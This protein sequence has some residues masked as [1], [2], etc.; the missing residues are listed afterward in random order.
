MRRRKGHVRFRRAARQFGFV[1][2]ING[3]ARDKLH[4]H[5]GLFGKFFGDGLI[6]QIFKTAAPRA[7]NQLVSGHR[8]TCGQHARGQQ[9]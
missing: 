9:R 4:F 8:M 5:A 7:D 6:N 1:Q 2:T 3:A